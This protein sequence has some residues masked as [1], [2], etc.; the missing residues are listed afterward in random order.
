MPISSMRITERKDRITFDGVD[1]YMIPM[2]YQ[3]YIFY[4]LA[5]IYRI[6]Y[7]DAISMMFSNSTSKIRRIVDNVLTIEEREGRHF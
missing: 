4:K 6:S 2:M 5:Y 1:K 7:N 3:K